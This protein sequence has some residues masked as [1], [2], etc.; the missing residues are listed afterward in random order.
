MR[1]TAFDRFM[2]STDIGYDQWHDGEGYDLDALAELTGA[3]RAAAEA[4]LLGRADRDWRDI[5]ALVA[6]G[7]AQARDAVVNQLRHGTIELRLAAARRLPEDPAIEED[8]EAAI[9][10]GLA[11]ATVMNGLTTALD[12][13]AEHRTAPIIDALFRAALRDDR[14]MAVH[15]AAL[16]LF[17][18]GKAT[19]PFDW[20]RR[21][22]T[23]QFGAEDPKVR[24][25]AFEQLCWECGADA[26]HYLG[27]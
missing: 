13:A 17:L 21:S 22:F 23:L 14:L 25:A 6:L 7:T 20:D 27:A 9:V 19:E 3:E 4:W 12:L 15:A 1:T 2:A 10:D 11:T 5:E 16:L 18:H 8:R 26:A 24:R